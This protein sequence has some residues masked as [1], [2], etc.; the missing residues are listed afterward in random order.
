[1]IP[2]QNDPVVDEIRA[3][4]IRFP[5]RFGHDPAQLVAYYIKLQEQH[6]DRMVEVPVTRAQTDQPVR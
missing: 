1:M 6:R 4:D 2:K 3:C 5:E